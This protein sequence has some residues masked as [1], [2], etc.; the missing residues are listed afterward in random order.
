MIRRTHSPHYTPEYAPMP[1]PP[2]DRARSLVD[3]IEEHAGYLQGY[4]KEDGGGTVARQLEALK[5]KVGE[6]FRALGLEGEDANLD[7]VITSIR[8]AVARFYEQARKTEEQ[9]QHIIKLTQQLEEVRAFA[10]QMA[11]EARNSREAL[12]A[13]ESLLKDSKQRAQQLEEKT[14]EFGEAAR[15]AESENK[16]AQERVNIL[17]EDLRT[18][19]QEYL[20][21]DAE[22]KDARRKLDTVLRGRKE[23]QIEA[24]GQVENEKKQLRAAMEQANAIAMEEK[25]RA[26]EIEGRLRISRLQQEELAANLRRIQ[27]E[28]ELYKENATQE[29]E[30]AEAA[31]QGRA[32]ETAEL[33]QEAD[34]A[35]AERARVQRR[36]DEALRNVQSAGSARDRREHRDSDRANTQEVPDEEFVPDP[37][38]PAKRLPPK[39]A[40]SLLQDMGDAA[41]GAPDE[42]E[43]GRG[44]ADEKDGGS[45]GG[46]GSTGRGRWDERQRDDGQDDYPDDQGDGAW[47]GGGGDEDGGWDDGQGTGDAQGDGWEEEEEYGE[48]ETFHV[49]RFPSDFDLSTRLRN[50]GAVARVSQSAYDHAVNVYV[51][52][53]TQHATAPAQ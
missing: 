24:A 34:R 49:P 29:K 31:E 32:K 5:S 12:A 36:L 13:T 4:A 8:E 44:T 39:T 37:A 20:K 28:V 53:C 17:E 14:K 26:D 46:Q 40:P 21:K 7:K 38:P 25:R 10:E 11:T 52:M 50:Q 19:K 22:A 41:D 51:R 45:A 3:Q 48:T 9:G 47:G 23:E 30:R 43:D 35:R 2:V 16:L 1:S 33:K 18:S 15:A 42:A 6:L 27:L